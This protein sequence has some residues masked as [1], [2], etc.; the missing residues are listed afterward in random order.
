MPSEFSIVTATKTQAAEIATLIM[1]AMDH[2]CCLNFA[3]PHHDLSDFHRMLTELVASDVSQYSYRNTLAA[4]TRQGDLAGICVA[5]DGHDLHRLRQAFVEAAG[6][7]L[8]RDFSGMDDETSSGEYYIDSLAV[9]SEYR[10]R[11]VASAL[12]HAVIAAHGHHQPVGLLVDQGN[13][14]GEKLYQ[15]IGFRVVGETAWGGHPMRHMQYPVK[16]AWCHHDALSER[17]HDEAWGVPVHDDRDHFMY[18]LMESMSCGLS[19]EMM[20]RRREVFRTCFAGFDAEKVAAF[21]DADVDRIMQTEGMIRSQRKIQAVIRNARAFVEVA[22]AFGTFDRYIWHFTEGHTLIYPTHAHTPVTRNALSD[23]VA[24]D[25]RQRGFR[26]VGSTIIYSHLQ[27]IGIIND[28][29]PDCFRYAV[30]RPGCKC[31]A[32]DFCGRDE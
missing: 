17:Y 30:L 11:G 8:G 31:V 5:Y 9:K 24:A 1:A 19:W 14:Q 16:C 7:H 12:L 23:R 32:D 15:R 21:T 6:R 10:R 20:L 28:H 13:P 3:G 22:R 18:L 2:D 25:L 27:G 29:H 26:Y 4:V